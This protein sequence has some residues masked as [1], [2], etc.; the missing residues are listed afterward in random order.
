MRYYQGP[1]HKAKRRIPC[2]YE[3]PDDGYNDNTAL[4]LDVLGAAL[5]TFLQ[6]SRKA[7]AIWVCENSSPSSQ[8]EKTAKLELFGHQKASANYP[9]SEMSPTTTIFRSMFACG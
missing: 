7:S 9:K 1:V 4:Q 3:S 2:R 8:N 6:F 5:A